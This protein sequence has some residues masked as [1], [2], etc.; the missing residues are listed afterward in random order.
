MKNNNNQREKMIK[1]SMKLL[2]KQEGHND[3]MKIIKALGKE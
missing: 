3:F 2:A 1:D